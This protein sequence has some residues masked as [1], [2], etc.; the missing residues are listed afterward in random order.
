M[1]VSLVRGAILMKKYVVLALVL[2]LGLLVSALIVE[3]P[4]LA[5]ASEAEAGAVLAEDPEGWL[6][7]GT[8]YFNPKDP[9]LNVPKL[10]GLGVTLNFGNPFAWLVLAGVIV[11][12]IVTKFLPKRKG[13]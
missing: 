13:M 12:V 7:G 1:A 5:I 11:L 8:F 9:R 10:R 6:F 4:R 2:T 3:Q